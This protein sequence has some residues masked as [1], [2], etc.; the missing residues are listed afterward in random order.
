MAIIA[1]LRHPITCDVLQ[2]FPFIRQ[3]SINGIPYGKIEMDKNNR[4]KD[5]NKN[6]E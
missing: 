4:K 6:A 5:S 2:N 1:K 3:I